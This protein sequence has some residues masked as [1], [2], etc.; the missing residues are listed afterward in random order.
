VRRP[1]T[2]RAVRLT[3]L[4]ETAHDAKYGIV[5]PLETHILPT[6]CMVFSGAEIG[7]RVASRL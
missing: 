6:N 1:T 3:R 4:C 7:A 2:I 5:E